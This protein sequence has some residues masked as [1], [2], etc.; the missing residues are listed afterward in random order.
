M[1][2]L[3]IDHVPFVFDVVFGIQ[4]IKNNLSQIFQTIGPF[5]PTVKRID[6][7]YALFSITATTM[8][9]IITIFIIFTSF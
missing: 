1:E 8:R 3:V 2:R 9:P 4:N 6:Q 7:T 5:Y